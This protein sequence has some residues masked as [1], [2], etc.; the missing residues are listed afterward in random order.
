M[1]SPWGDIEVCD[2]HV[3]FFSHGFFSALAKQVSARSGGDP[4]TV[5]SIAATL[6]WQAPP[7]EPEALASVWTEE[8]DRKGIQRAA[9]IASVPGDEAS[10]AAAVRSYPDRFY[11]YF[12]VDPTAADSVERVRAALQGGNLHCICLFPAMHRYS[13]QDERVRALLEAAGA[14]PDVAVFVHCGVLTVGVRAKLGLS[15]PFDMRFSNPIDLHAVALAFPKVR[16]IIPHFGAGYFREALMVCGLCPNVYLDT[17]SSNSWIRY[18]PERLD[19]AGI[20]RR[21]LDVAGP[22]RLLFG[23]DSAF[24]P[25]GWHGAIFEAQVEALQQVAISGLDARRIFGGNLMGLLGESRL[26]DS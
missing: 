14:H 22:E 1:Q 7:R 21:A 8:L 11:G 19:L 3:H 6:G 12:M 4:A 26:R 10:V 2:A 9:L 17:S 24:F 13:I 15:S 23:S 18:Q 5:E 16:F 20:F 25:R